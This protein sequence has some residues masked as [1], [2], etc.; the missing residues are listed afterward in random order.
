MNRRRD[1]RA[2]LVLALLLVLTFF[3]GQARRADAERGP[4]RR[5][6]HETHVAPAGAATARAVA[7]A[8]HG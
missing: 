7:D 4:E 3:L 5:L 8:G 6:P 1:K 2:A